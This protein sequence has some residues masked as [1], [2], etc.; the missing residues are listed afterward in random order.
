MGRVADSVAEAGLVVPY[1]EAG[2]GYN[3]NGRNHADDAGKLALV[4]L[5]RGRTRCFTCGNVFR[6]LVF[7]GHGNSL[8][9]AAFSPAI[10]PNTMH[11]PQDRPL[12]EMGYCTLKRPPCGAPATAQARNDLAICVVHVAIAV[13]LKTAQVRQRQGNAA[14]CRV[15]RAVFQS[16]QALADLPKS[17]SK[18]AL[19]SLL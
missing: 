13:G 16:E 6:G 9:A 19:H 1:H 17:S 5:R 8:P 15:E 11:M 10:L 2:A 3:H 18:P 4:A 12:S 14:L 7:L